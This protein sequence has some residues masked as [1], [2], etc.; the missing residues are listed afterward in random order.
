MAEKMVELFRTF[1]VDNSGS[2]DCEELGAV[3]QNCDPR[4]WTDAK[5]SELLAVIDLDK[6]RSISYEEFVH[7]ICGT[8]RWRKARRE[9]FKQVGVTGDELDAMKDSVEKR[10]IKH[11]GPM[12]DKAGDGTDSLSLKAGSKRPSLEASVAPKAGSR[13]PSLE[14]NADAKAG[15][16]RPPTTPAIEAS[17]VP[18]AG[19]RIMPPLSRPGSR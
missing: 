7:W 11:H 2:I 12:V 9:F 4:K 3:L 16:R 10:G 8:V 19:S 17:L 15:P 18:K 14:A 6:N 1:D 5:V 13:R